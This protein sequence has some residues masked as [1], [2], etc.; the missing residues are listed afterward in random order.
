MAVACAA[1]LHGGALGSV[2]AE[3]LPDDV[4]SALRENA[5]ALAPI[6]VRWVSTR[7]SPLA[8]KELRSRMNTRTDGSFLHGKQVRVALQGGKALYEEKTVDERGRATREFAKSFDGECIFQRIGGLGAGNG[9]VTRLALR[10]EPAAAEYHAPYFDSAGFCIPNTSG[11]FAERRP[12]ESS[13]LRA[14]ER[15]ELRSVERVELDQEAARRVE[16]VNGA[17]TDAYWLAP[18]LGFAVVRHDHSE[19]GQLMARRTARDHRQAKPGLWLPARTRRE[20]YVEHGLRLDD[21][22]PVVVEEHRVVD[23]RVGAIEES[24]FALQFPAGARVADSRWPEARELGEQYLVYEQPQRSEELDSAI[25]AGVVQ[26]KRE[27]AM[28]DLMTYLGAPFV[29]HR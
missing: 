14:L 26:R 6:E 28:R 7:V 27:V 9:F 17:A 21:G 18:R 11:Q 2:S 3:D 15:E 23:L 20:S 24:V 25:R 29:I 19:A 4:R 13:L 5:A 16:I 1:L 8:L 22:R 10:T 12:P